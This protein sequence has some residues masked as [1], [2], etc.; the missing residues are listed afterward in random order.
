MKFFEPTHEDHLS[1]L[2]AEQLLDEDQ[3]PREAYREGIEY[4]E[5]IKE[6]YLSSAVLRVMGAVIAD[7]Y[8]HG[9]EDAQTLEDIMAP[10]KTAYEDPTQEFTEAQSDYL[11]ACETLK[12]FQ[13][14]I[15]PKE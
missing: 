5:T 11:L 7:V 12:L 15:P 9:P 1:D 6:D 13:Q 4:I 10:L 8:A 3:D 14:H 2:K